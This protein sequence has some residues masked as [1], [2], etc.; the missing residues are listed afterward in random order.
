MITQGFLQGVFTQFHTDFAKAYEA[1]EVWYQ[2]I[3]T[4]YPSKSRTNVYF[5]M[6]QFAVLREWIG[7]RTVESIATYLQSV[8]NKKF[9]ES[10]TLERDDIEDDQ[11]GAFTPTVQM[12][13]EASKKWPDQQIAAA[14]EAANSTV[15]Y[16]GANYFDASHPVNKYDATVKARN[17]TDTTQSNLFPSTALT[18]DNFKK[19]KA[20]MRGW[21]GEN[22]KPLGVQPDLLVVPPALE[23]DA[24][25]ILNAGIIAPAQL[26]GQTM[27]GSNTNTLNTKGV[28]LLVIPELTDDKSWYLMSTKRAV[29]PFGWQLRYAPDL[30]PQV[31]PSDPNV[32]NLDQYRYNVRAR[33]VALTSLWWLA[34][35][36]TGP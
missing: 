12:L 25:L 3:A 18:P 13:G 31:S 34:A 28:D 10:V 21:V 33:G 24:R 17:G 30:V 1:Q 19:V 7:P 4:I 9:Q 15:I 23:E 14:M 2:R 8:S 5:W 11:Y 26:F 29:K 22:G 32:V 6:Q 16:D 35:K 20:A 27:V 36:C